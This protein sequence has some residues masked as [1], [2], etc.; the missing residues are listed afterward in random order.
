[1][2]DAQ[3][4]EYPILKGNFTGAFKTLE[5]AQFAWSFADEECMIRGDERRFDTCGINFESCEY[6]TAATISYDDQIHY[7]NPPRTAKEGMTP[8]LELRFTAI[9]CEEFDIVLC[10]DCVED[11]AARDFVEKLVSGYS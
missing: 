4:D 10:D 11:P 8:P 5:Q 3:Q 7:Y 1:M 9:D 6:C 2:E